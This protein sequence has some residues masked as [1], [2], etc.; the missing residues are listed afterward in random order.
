M[1]EIFIEYLAV[2][3]TILIALMVLIIIVGQNYSLSRQVKQRLSYA[4]LLTMIVVAA[5]IMVSYFELKGQFDHHGSVIG[6]VIGFAVSPFVLSLLGGVFIE[7]KKPW[8][9]KL[10]FIPMATN[11]VMSVLSPWFGFVFNISDNKYTRGPFFFIYIIACV[12]GA[13][14]LYIN[15]YLINRRYNDR[16]RYI[17]ALLSALLLA[18]LVVEM[19]YPTAHISWLCIAFSII[20]VYAYFC[21]LDE[22]LDAVTG[23]F[24][25]R[26]YDYKL[27]SIKVSPTTAVIIMDIDFF[28]AVNDK[29]GHLY[30]DECLR[31]IGNIIRKNFSS[32]GTCYR[33]GGDEFG[34]IAKNVTEL[35]IKHSVSSFNKDIAERREID[36]RIPMVSSG[37]SMCSKDDKSIYDTIDNA[38]KQ[39]YFYKDTRKSNGEK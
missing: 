12:C 22:K 3:A 10:L 4:S 32:I 1:K 29:Y 13:I 27:A 8:Y 28:K 20:I 34:C 39:M 30:G 9:Q 33:I 15:V 2:G 38:D 17:L 24:N 14:Y 21:E 5:E 26:F 31:E 7:E 23:I 18:G 6:D 16:S 25:R 11:F 36:S 37:Y 35:E 19:I